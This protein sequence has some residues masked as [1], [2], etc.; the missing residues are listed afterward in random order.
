MNS[1]LYKRKDAR[2]SA[3]EETVRKMGL[4]NYTTAH[5]KQKIKSLSAT[6]HQESHK[7]EKSLSSGAG[8]EDVYKPPMK[9]FTLMA[10]VMKSGVLKR[11][12]VSTSAICTS[13]NLD[14][15]LTILLH[16]FLSIFLLTHLKQ[17][18]PL[19]AKLVNVCER[20]LLRYLLSFTCIKLLVH[21]PCLPTGLV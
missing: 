18:P 15:F 20:Y 16:F 14:T 17:R 4:E 12:T 2:Q 7:I 11:G 9:R 8:L 10:E 6:Y 5:A 3:M 21:L 1:T 19:G 13:S